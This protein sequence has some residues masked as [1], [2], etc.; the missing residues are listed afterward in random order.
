[1]TELETIRP[2]SERVVLEKNEPEQVTKGGIII[3]GSVEDRSLAW[4]A[5]VRAVGPGRLLDS[6]ERVPP[7]VKIGDVVLVGSYMG[8]ELKTMRDTTQ[9]PV[10]VVKFDDIL[11]IVDR[12]ES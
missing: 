8:V 7:D 9:K 10:M 1:M 5:T 4:Q 2:M 12:D 3:P 6:G 11:G